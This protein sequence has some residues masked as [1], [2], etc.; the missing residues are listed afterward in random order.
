MPSASAGSVHLARTERGHGVASGAIEHTRFPINLRSDWRRTV[1]PFARFFQTLRLLLIARLMGHVVGTAV[2]AVGL[3]ACGPRPILRSRNSAALRV[4]R[5][6]K[7]G[8]KRRISPGTNE[9]RTLQPSGN[10]CEWQNPN[11]RSYTARGPAALSFSISSLRCAS[12]TKPLN[13]ARVNRHLYSRRLVTRHLPICAA[14]E[15][16]EPGRSGS[17][18]RT[19]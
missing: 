10:R 5:D 3:C 13:A 6:H 14:Q 7:T 1:L 2:G 12:R 4:C 15:R 8:A 16:S 11:N 19:G 9:P 17:I 18:A